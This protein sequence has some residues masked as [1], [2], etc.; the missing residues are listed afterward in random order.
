[1]KGLSL[2]MLLAEREVLGYPGVTVQLHVNANNL[3]IKY[4]TPQGETEL[5]PKD[6][7]EAKDMYFHPFVYGL[8]V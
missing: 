1:M 5:V 8:N 7:A 3:L 4:R 2:P 6:R